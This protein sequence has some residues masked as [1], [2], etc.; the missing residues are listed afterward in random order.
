MTNGLSGD[1]SSHPLVSA[2][3]T[4]QGLVLR[5]DGR[6]DHSQ[7]SEAVS[8]FVE[9]RRSFLEGNQ[10]AIEWIGGAPD[11]ILKRKVGDMLRQQFRIHVNTNLKVASESYSSRSDS[12]FNADGDLDSDDEGSSDS[13]FPEDSLLDSAML[14]SDQIDDTSGESLFGGMDGLGVQ[15]KGAI[16]GMPITGSR[17]IDPSLWDDPDARIIYSTLRSGQRI[18]TEHSLVV[19]GDVNSG[20][21]VVA[22]GDIIVLG[23]L[24]GVAHAGAYD[25]TGGRRFI[26][27]LGL[28]S[29]QLRIGSIISCGSAQEDG[30]HGCEIARVEGNN[31]V[32]E[33]Y[34]S[35]TSLMSARMGR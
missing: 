13:I 25:E 15:S 6:A 18:E 31:I 20:A 30:D 5:V 11:E 24:R 1:S 29:S 10:I 14:D 34:R 3:G 19:C 7:V 32:V 8:D 21:E 33:P 26:M 16:D 23:A 22:G 9:S 27:A 2:K 17:S 28:K 12:V 35:R 4:S